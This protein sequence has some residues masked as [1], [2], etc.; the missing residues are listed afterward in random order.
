MAKVKEYTENLNEVDEK[1]LKRIFKDY[2]FKNGLFKKEIDLEYKLIPI[3]EEMYKTLNNAGELSVYIRDKSQYIYAHKIISDTIM[4]PLFMKMIDSKGFKEL[5][6]KKEIIKDALESLIDEKSGLIYK[7]LFP[8]T[9][10]N[11]FLKHLSHKDSEK[12]ERKINDIHYRKKYR[13]LDQA[14]LSLIDLIK[15]EQKNTCQAL[16]SKTK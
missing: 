3:T 7:E 10:L 8:N 15:F 2:F 5:R 14:I 16:T 6:I 12:L 4:N 1:I 9:K 11:C 13:L